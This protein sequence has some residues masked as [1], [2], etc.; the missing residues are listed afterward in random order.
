MLAPTDAAA[1]VAKTYLSSVG[2]GRYFA[3]PH[4]N[5]FLDGGA[6]AVVGQIDGPG[7]ASLW[8][9]TLAS[10]R[11]VKI[12]GFDLIGSRNFV[13]Y[14]IAEDTELLATSDERSI[15]TVNL[16]RTPY[17]ARRLYTVPSGYMLDDLVS[18]RQDGSAVVAGIRPIGRLAP[19]TGIRVRTSDGAVTRLLTKAFFAN[20]WQH[21]PN[22]QSWIG[23]SRDQGN[24][25]RIWGYHASQAPSGRLLW[26][27]RS[28]TGG[29]LLVGHELWCR[30]DLTILAVAYRSS[31]GGPR[32]L[33]QVWP[34]GRSRLVQSANNYAHCNVSRDGRRA[35][36]DTTTGGVIV[37]NLSGRA[38]AR[39]LADTYVRNMHPYH[40]HP[41]F[42][43]DG[44]KIIYTDTNAAGQVRV[45]MI[46]AG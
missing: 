4:Q 46:P 34:D 6:R 40:A 21:S 45:T 10:G 11:S 24:R 25:Q 16:R 41:H 26:N 13:Y 7:R 38:A 35:V 28:P 32:G 15:W 18:I 9:L 1:D 14:D 42:T 30:H 43:P 5:A 12:A 33:Y 19:V 17:A 29:E 23:F 22:N 31:P 37:M 3:Y 8:L 39:Q 27:Q 36:V 44:R 20:H 2:Q